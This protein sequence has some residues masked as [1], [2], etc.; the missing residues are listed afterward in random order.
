MLA[1]ELIAK[2]L[3]KHGV[4]EACREMPH[5]MGEIALPFI[6]R[7]VLDALKEPVSK[8]GQED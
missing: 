1:G 7:N 3:F 2:E 6:T 5:P 4:K 8:Y